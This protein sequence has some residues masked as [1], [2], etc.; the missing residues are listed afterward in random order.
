MHIIFSERPLAYCISKRMEALER[1]L[2]L[3]WGTIES[4]GPHF[5]RFHTCLEFTM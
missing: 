1:A 4:G 3:G 5:A 2:G